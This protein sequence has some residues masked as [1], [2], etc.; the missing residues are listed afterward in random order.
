MIEIPLTQGKIA[1]ISDHQLDRVIQ[2]TWFTDQVGGRYYAAT[3]IGYDKVRLHRFLLNLKPDDPDVDHKNG[4]TLDCQD[5]NLRLATRSQNMA[6]QPKQAGRLSSKYKGVT[7]EK[8]TGKWVAQICVNYKNR[9]LGRFLVEEDAARAYDEAAWS[10]WG[11]FAVL[12]FPREGVLAI[13]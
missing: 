5:E 7:W 2:H 4:N 9:K 12:N 8:R 10:A 1:L 3:F 11:E 6:N 13:A